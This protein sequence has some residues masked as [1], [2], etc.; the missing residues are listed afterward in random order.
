MNAMQLFQ[1]PAAWR[2]YSERAT[3]TQEQINKNHCLKR[4]SKQIAH[5]PRN[6]TGASVPNLA[7]RTNGDE[8]DQ[9]AILYEF[10]G[11]ACRKSRPALY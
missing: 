1:T 5:P 9:N 2:V 7:I 10:N 6:K 11:Q 3:H 4:T 8:N